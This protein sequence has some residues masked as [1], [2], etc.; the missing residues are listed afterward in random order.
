M[1]N[2]LLLLILL[3]SRLIYPLKHVYL[4]CVC[5]VAWDIHTT[6]YPFDFLTQFSAR[7]ILNAIFVSNY[8]YQYVNYISRIWKYNRYYRR[9]QW[10]H[11]YLRYVRLLYTP[12]L[13]TVW[14]GSRSLALSCSNLCHHRRNYRNRRKFHCDVDLQH[15][16]ISLNISSFDI[17]YLKKKMKIA[18]INICT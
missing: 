2:I 18:K 13:K 9:L 17:I 8:V 15:V 5:F 6:L 14:T 10:R 4:I 16:C 7:H 3:L 11:Q 1:N 12:S